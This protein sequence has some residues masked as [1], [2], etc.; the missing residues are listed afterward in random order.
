M[1]FSKYFNK[2]ARAV[3][4]AGAIGAAGLGGFAGAHL[5]HEYTQPAQSNYTLTQ[6]AAVAE[7][8]LPESMLQKIDEQQFFPAALPDGVTLPQ[9]TVQASADAYQGFMD[10]I[11]AIG[12][13]G[14]DKT[15]LAVGFINDL[16]LS[17]D[18]SEA[19]YTQ[20]INTYKQSGGP[21]VSA[22][23]DNYE[24]GVMY[25]QEASAGVQLSHAF[26]SIFD[27]DDA[28][29]QQISKEVG[30]AMQQGQDLYN[31]AGLEGGAAGGFAG[32]LLMT[33]LLLAARKRRYP[34]AKPD[35]NKTPKPGNP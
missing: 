35:G 9:E 16:R 17:P 7:N 5:A 4:A 2:K 32:L 29:P 13:A 14:A 23:T 12:N 30:Q 8:Q 28:T 15:D 21:D 24:S 1:S 18:I 26:G 10:R 6:I 27:D 3:V 19:Q 34:S 20:L 33:P 22:V 11:A 25:Q 31:A